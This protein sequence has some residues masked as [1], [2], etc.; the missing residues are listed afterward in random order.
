MIL[1]IHW[2]HV[3]HQHQLHLEDISSISS[4]DIETELP[5]PLPS[6]LLSGII[7][8]TDLQTSEVL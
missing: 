2:Q 6:P 7:T 3:V 1:Y 4:L 5:L 8:T